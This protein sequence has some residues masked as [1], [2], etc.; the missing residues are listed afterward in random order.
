MAGAYF[1]SSPP[2]PPTNSHLLLFPLIF[3]LMDC[4]LHRVIQSKQALT[5]KHFKCFVKQMLEGIKAM[6]DVGIFHRDLKPGNILVSKDCQL[7]ITDFGLARYM[8]DSTRSG[9]N[10]QIPM[11]EYVV[12]RW[13]RPPEILL[14]PNRPYS[15]AID[16]W[17]IGCILAELIRRKPL[18]PGKTHANQVQLIFELMGYRP[19]QDV[20][21]PLSSEAGM[22]LEKR[23]RFPGFPLK[24][25]TPD[26]SDEALVILSALLAVDPQRRPS[27]AEA[28]RFDYLAGAEVPIVYSTSSTSISKPPV[29]FFDFEQEHYSC[30]QLTELIRLEAAGKEE[31][32]FHGAPSQFGTDLS[33]A[34]ASYFFGN[35]TQGLPGE[36]YLGGV[37]SRASSR[38][39]V[40]SG[41]ASQ[42]NT[43]LRGNP[44]TVA[45]FAAALNPSQQGVTTS[46]SMDVDNSIVQSTGGHAGPQKRPAQDRTLAASITAAV[47]AANP[48]SPRRRPPPSPSKDKVESIIQREAKTRRKAMS[49]ESTRP[50]LAQPKPPQQPGVVA[51]ALGPVSNMI[52]SLQSTYNSVRSSRSAGN[53]VASVA[54]F[55]STAVVSSSAFGR[56][57]SSHEV[58]SDDRR[59]STAPAP[60]TTTTSVMSQAKVDSLQRIRAEAAASATEP[61]QT[62]STAPASKAFTSKGLLPFIKR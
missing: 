54:N 59:V 33:A 24:Q 3:Q 31:G 40:S 53:M 44:S 14:A 16:L 9:V 50:P 62:S 52:S 29:G 60:T 46:E 19:G 20:G 35:N 55:P 15:E 4:D 43:Q 47:S 7:R 11:T 2:P 48:N 12:T 21:F 10:K 51:S 56:G 22:F 57:G 37:Q 25:A 42:M 26:A 8:H 30:A 13:Y 41:P 38:E 28:L 58:H 1:Y 49:E 61:Q 17:S 5:D 23:C 32:I 18:F 36:A 27:A 6:H 45:S 39:G 34:H